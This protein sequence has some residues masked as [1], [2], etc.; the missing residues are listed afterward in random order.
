MQS[1][2]EEHRSSGSTTETRSDTVFRFYSCS[3][4]IVDRHWNTTI[5]W[6]K[7]LSSVR[8]HDP[9]A[10]TW[11]NSPS[12]NWRSSSCRRRFGRVQEKSMVFRNGHSTIGYQFWQEEEDPRKGFDI[13]WIQTLPVISCISEYFKDIQEIMLLISCVARRCTV[14]QRI[15]WVYLSRRECKWND[16]HNQKWCWFLEDGVSKE[17]EWERLHATWP[18]QGSSQTE[19]FR[20]RKN[21]VYWCN[22]KLAQVKGLQFYQTRS[23]TIVLDDTLPMHW[24]KRYVWKRR[25]SSS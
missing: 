25:T 11:L 23:H 5:T 19:I 12:G 9:I 16:F 1:Q 8:S 3:W 22:L 21:I 2:E 17:E 10:T 14:T 13:A 20:N 15:Y 18:S 6:S 7:V 24:E 4:Q